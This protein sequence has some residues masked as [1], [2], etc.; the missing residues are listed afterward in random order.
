MFDGWYADDKFQTP[1]L[2]G[3]YTIT[4]PEGEKQSTTLYAKFSPTTTEFTITFHTD[5]TTQIPQKT[6]KYAH[7]LRYIQ[8]I[9]KLNHV[10]EGW[11]LDNQFNTKVT[12]NNYNRIEHLVLSNLDLYAKWESVTSSYQYTDNDNGGVTFS[13]DSKAENAKIDTITIPETHNGKTITSISDNAFKDFG[14]LEEIVLP[15]TITHI[16]SKAFSNTYM[17]KNINI[18]TSLVSIGSRAFSSSSANV[19]VVLPNS[20]TTI[21]EYAFSSSKI[22]SL[23]I[24]SGITNI[25]KAMCFQCRELIS[26]TLPQTVTHI[27]DLAFS[28][29]SK[30]TNITI[31]QSVVEIGKLAFFQSGLVQ[32]TL[33]QSLTTIK[34][35]AFKNTKL[36]TIEIP[37]L[38]E[39]IGNQAFSIEE[40]QSFTVNANNQS[41]SAADGV[42]YD[43]N[44]TKI[45][46]YPLSHTNTTYTLPSTI[47]TISERQF[48]LV[49]NLEIFNGHS[50]LSEIK[51]Y[52][53]QKMPNL[54]AVNN[55]DSITKLGSSVFSENINL[56]TIL[57]PT[58]ISILPEAT[59]NATP[60]L[61]NVVIPQNIT[62]IQASAFMDNG[63]PIITIPN[64][65][66][67]VDDQAFLSKSLVVLN[68]AA[69]VVDVKLSA[70]GGNGQQTT[71][72][73]E[74]ASKPQG[75]ITNYNQGRNWQSSTVIFNRTTDI[76]YTFDVDGG[77]TISPIISKFAILLP[78]PTKENN[79]FNGWYTDQAK[80]NKIENTTY[81]ADSNTTL[82]AG[83]T[84][85]N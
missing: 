31:P 59:F 54:Q 13:M 34:Q 19:D 24:P 78:T 20:V 62:H 46:Q 79:T 38:V 18:P 52:A 70:F 68:V 17:L 1:M 6:V 80:T 26:V 45:I 27:G 43:K 63:S 66:T 4:K 2:S 60:K 48:Y 16:G 42:L 11:Y 25:P 40:L 12:V 35:E 49:K 8:N 7:M 71:V 33:P 82:Y 84:P 30:L 10:L 72:Y 53:F 51:D 28:S 75:W 50:T 56:T 37:E 61:V 5:A 32:V 73:T 22:K 15:N 29:T 69:S 57:I 55:I 64:S 36:T 44:V 76:T 58:K 14:N 9:T 85:N 47:D 67:A 81:I 39:T 23:T 3:S 77:N 83:F 65:V 74:H 21:G 41:F